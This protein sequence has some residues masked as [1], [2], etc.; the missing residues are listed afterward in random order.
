MMG[1]LSD[2]VAPLFP[3]ARATDATATDTDVEPLFLK[4]I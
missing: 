1:A 4:V 3:V 2:E